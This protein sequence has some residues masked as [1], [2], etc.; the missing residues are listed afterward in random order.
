MFN[1][2]KLMKKQ[3]QEIKELILITKVK[4]NLGESQSVYFCTIRQQPS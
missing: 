2:S 3:L 4:Y 1:K